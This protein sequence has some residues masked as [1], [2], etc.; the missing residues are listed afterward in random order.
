MK[1][2]QKNAIKV[3]SR[4]FRRIR[5]T[6]PPCQDPAPSWGN[7][8]HLLREGLAA[9]IRRS[10]RRCPS[11]F[12]AIGCT[13]LIL[14]ARPYRALALDVNTGSRSASAAVPANP[15]LYN[16]VVMGDDRVPG[17]CPPKSQP[18]KPEQCPP[19]TANE[20]QVK[21][22]FNEIAA[23]S[24]APAYVFFNG[25]LVLGSDNVA[26]TTAQLSA[27]LK[28]VPLKLV[29]TLVPIPGNHE[30]NRKAGLHS[31][32]GE[33]KEWLTVMGKRGTDGPGPKN[34]PFLYKKNN[35]VYNLISDQSSLTYSLDNYYSKTFPALHDHFILINTDPESPG[36]STDNASTVPVDWLNQN[37][38]LMAARNASHIF[39]LGHKQAYTP[40]WIGGMSGLDCCHDRLEMRDT[41]FKYLNDAGAAVYFTGH[42]HIWWKSGPGKSGHT[43]QVIIGN[44]GAPRRGTETKWKG[45]YFGFTVVKVMSSG[46]IMIASYGRDSDKDILA[47]SPPL[48][49]PTTLRDCFCIGQTGGP[50]TK[51]CTS[52]SKQPVSGLPVSLN[53]SLACTP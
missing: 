28:I 46:Q 26:D 9:N 31:L 3:R 1:P 25:D 16:F 53:S 34:R 35:I 12:L 49:Y 29:P 51:A 45:P 27:W 10:R 41:M 6:L 43:W 14:A 15:P 13:L 40:S 24:P 37:L 17:P 7:L 48:K 44:A 47:P 38:H 36:D 2:E 11:I 50:N 32:H 42:V 8:S 33:E 52:T 4:Q 22:S 30:F 39:V 23:L 19:S 21:R 20:N 5:Q 18:A